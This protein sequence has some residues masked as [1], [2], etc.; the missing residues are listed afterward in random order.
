MDERGQLARDGD[1]ASVFVSY[2]RADKSRAQQIIDLLEGAGFQVWWDEALEAGTTYVETTEQALESA[3]AVV[4]LWTKT[5]TGSNW[6][7][8]EAMSGRER[9]CLVP[10]SLD[11]STAP[12]GFRQFQ[13]LDFSGW[14]GRATDPE[15]R[16]LVAAVAGMHGREMPA[17]L[18][19]TA[20]PKLSR[21]VVLAGGAVAIAVGLAGVAVL[22][23]ELFGSETETNSIAVLPFRNLSGDPEQDYFSAGLAEELRITLSLNR[24][25]L[26]AAETSSRIFEEATDNVAEA[27]QRL[28]VAYVLEGS[29]RRSAELLRITARLVDVASGFEVWSQLFERD[30]EDALDLH[31]DLATSVVDELFA[32]NEDGVI[33]TQRPGGT[34]NSEALDHYLHGLALLRSAASEETDRE[35]LAELERAIA[36]DPEYAVGHATYGWGMAVVAA[37]HSSGED[38]ADAM[39]RAEALAKRAIKLE[40]NAAEG[41]AALGIIRQY[42]LDL[43]GAREPYQTSFELGFGNAQI[44]AAFAQF[45]AYAGEFDTASDAIARALRIDPLNAQVF[46]TAALIEF[47]AGNFEGAQDHAQT[48]LSLNPDASSLQWILG[49]IALLSGDFAAARELFRERISHPGAV[50]RPCHRRRTAFRPSGWR[51]KNCRTGGGIWR[52]QPVSA[53]ASVCDVG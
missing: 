32:A 49:D 20:P 27:A 16:K 45:S 7:R 10:V 43:R 37:A 15:A 36:I 11:G 26:V 35:A 2:S 46:R 39:R 8:D 24:R 34:Q 29:V 42:N 21:R 40:P 51:C 23:P 14:G 48:A 41:H 33:I 38:L 13:A 53:G 31:S 3:E 12:L 44:I 17:R 22:K 52:Q 30:T 19:G 25:L 5:S 9:G 47:L 50:A 6:V 4:V 1:G 18:P 28:G